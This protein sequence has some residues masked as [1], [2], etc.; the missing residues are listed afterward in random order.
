MDNILAKVKEL[1][2]NNQQML[3]SSLVR[4]LSP[5]SQLMLLLP[6]ISVASSY[7]KWRLVTLLAGQ[8]TPDLF[9]LLPPE[10][11][12][13][14]LVYVDGP[15]LLKASQVSR[16][17][18]RLLRSQNKIWFKK[19]KE[20]G[21]NTDNF[22][23]DENWHHIY[24]SSLRQLA[25]MKDGTA[26]TEKFMH[27][28]NCKKAVKA[29]D[30]QNGYLCTVSE[31][32]YVNIWYL[33]LNI[34]VLTFL[35]QRAVCCIKFKPN[36][37]LVCGH[38]MGIL[39]SW[40][41]SV[42]N[43][44]DN[45]CLVYDSLSDTPGEDTLLQCKFK[46]HAGPVFSCDFSKELNI[47]VSGG[48][49]ECIK[50]WSLSSGLVIRSLPN[51]DHWVLKVILLPDLTYALNHTIICMTRN[52]VLKI[53]WPCNGHS[54][55][56]NVKSANEYEQCGA[57]DRMGNLNK[58][59]YQC[60]IQLNEGNN[61]FF[62]PGL[63]Q[64]TKFVG[65]IKQD[66]DEKHA[67]LCIYDIETFQI[68]HNITLTFKV[69]KL[70]ALGNRFALLLTTGSVLY[71]STLMVIDI[72]TGEC[73]GTHSVPH[74]K[75]TTPDGAQLVVGDTEW[76]DGLR[77]YLPEE[78]SVSQS[79]SRNLL[80]NQYEYNA[81]HEAVGNVFTVNCDNRSNTTDDCCASA[82]TG[83]S[84]T[85]SC[86]TSTLVEFQDLD[87][88]KDGKEVINMKNNNSN[89]GNNTEEAASSLVQISSSIPIR[90]LERP[91]H[92]VL[93]AGVQSEPG[94]LFTLWWS[95]L[96]MMSKYKEE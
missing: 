92:L 33:K 49:D 22:H 65:L 56:D 11:Q 72:V 10:L 14:I 55:V 45:S 6:G 79:S 95:N 52:N 66:I 88:N 96:K 53:S 71:S 17:W 60:R 13:E 80:S 4:S 69:K 41:L 20:L 37:L 15:S 91:S 70:L 26:F 16:E 1:D 67:N 51:I 21:V 59:T 43:N 61:N 28:L 42:M 38:L 78:M 48:A 36:C 81:L 39:T 31:E 50:L 93:A 94:R 8:D 44:T 7:V 86:S 63:Q 40:D 19:C 87:R 73:A 90:K 24:V 46:M 64:S 77:G 12:L 18:N 85:P 25:C 5:E 68:A 76:L 2:L 89:N 62:T 74:S 27:L 34:P 3:L 23:N 84:S 29:V 54:D 35:V 57:Q 75:M 32:D 9:T 47:L 83:I 30:Y 82:E 58:I